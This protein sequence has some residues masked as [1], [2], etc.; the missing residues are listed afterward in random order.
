MEEEKTLSLKEAIELYKK[1]GPRNADFLFKWLYKVYE[2]TYLPS[3]DNNYIEQLALIKTKLC[4]FDVLIDDLADNAKLRNKRL[5][6]Q[7]IRIPNNGAKPYKN[8]YLEVTR[9]I[10]QDCLNSIKN[11]PRYEEFEDIFFFDIEQVLNSMKYSYLINIYDFSNYKEDEMYLNHGVMVMLHCDLDLMCSPDFNY[12][13]LGKLRPIL[14]SVQ[15][16]AHLGN[17]MNTYPK[18]ISEADFSSP[19]ISMGIREGLID[20]QSVIRDPESAMSNL[21]PLLARFEERMKNSLEKIQA[22]AHYIES[23]DIY[24]FYL[25]LRNVWEQFLQREQY[26]DSNKETIQDSPFQIISERTIKLG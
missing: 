25:K 3:I 21:K 19:I 6:D 20:K 18:E 14:H 24:E 5:L 10:W 13:E 12:E 8:L 4:I 22:S 2:K 15:D 26:W 17:M 16:V 11:L 9:L 7:A 1:V 23:I